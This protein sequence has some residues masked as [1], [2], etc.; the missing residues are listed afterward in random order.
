MSEMDSL[1][2]VRL[3][4][5][6]GGHRGKEMPPDEPFNP[7]AADPVAAVEA[8]GGNQCPDLGVKDDNFKAL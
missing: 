3:G 8:D 6:K 2:F 1:W 4:A 5:S 7:S